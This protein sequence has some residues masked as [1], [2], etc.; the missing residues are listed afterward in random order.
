MKTV[1]HPSP[2]YM[3]AAGHPVKTG[4]GLKIGLKTASAPQFGHNPA[5]R[6]P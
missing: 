3:G 6:R 4:D 1:T 2:F 5:K